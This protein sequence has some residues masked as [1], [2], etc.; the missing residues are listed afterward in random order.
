ME[1]CV[2]GLPAE[3]RLLG[4]PW[5]QNFETQPTWMLDKPSVLGASARVQV[6]NLA[7]PYSALGQLFPTFL[8]PG[9]GFV[10]DN[11]SM[12]QGWGWGEVASGMFQAHYV[13][14]ALYYYYNSS[15]SDHQEF[16]LD[17]GDPSPSW[18]AH[19]RSY[20]G[21]GYKLGGASSNFT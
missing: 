2:V 7:R 3:R 8:A 4:D 18:G 20:L 14:C 5:R 6:S 19:H 16:D 9:T 15:T 13:Y 10:V 12:D 21:G 17:A 11:F 1:S